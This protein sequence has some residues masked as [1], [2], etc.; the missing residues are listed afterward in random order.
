MRLAA[1]NPA[2]NV[3]VLRFQREA[4]QDGEEGAAVVSLPPTMHHLQ[5]VHHAQ[6]GSI[7]Q[8]TMYPAAAQT[9]VEVALA[10]D[11]ALSHAEEQGSAFSS[12]FDVRTIT[13]SRVLRDLILTVEAEQPTIVLVGRGRKSPALTHREELRHL[14]LN[15]TLGNDV[16]QD[17]SHS[18][19]QSAAASHAKDRALNSETCK[20]IGEPAMALTLAKTSAATLVLAS[21]VHGAGAAPAQQA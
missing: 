8:D 2:L 11:M 20:V 17:A 4:A 16:G 3:T 5:S 18:V 9:S 12:R 21:S 10:D 15:G 7:V 6:G 1:T 14:L 19:L 13:T